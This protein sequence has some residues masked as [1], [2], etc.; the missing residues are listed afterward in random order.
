[1]KIGILTFHR[2]PN[3]G[4]YLQAW[5][6]AEAVRRLGHP[7]EIINYQNPTLYE[8]EQPRL[9]S[10]HPARVRHT[11]RSWLK[12]RP[13][14][15]LVRDLSPGPFATSASNVNWKAYDT[16]VVGSDV[17]WD[18]QTPHFG[19]DPVYFGMAP[20]QQGSR[21]VSY[22][23]SC[24]PAKPSASTPDWVV[25]GLSKFAAIGVR[26]ENTFDLA[27][28][29]A[30]AIPQLVVDPTWLQKDPSS[31]RPLRQAAPYVLVYGDALDS[32]KATSLRAYCRRNGLRLVGAASAW[33]YCDTTVNGF[34]PFQW[35][36]LFSQATAVVTCTLHGLLYSI[37]LRKPFLMVTTEA[38]RQ[39]SRTVL[40][41]TNS[42]DRV[43]TEADPFSEK[44]LE[45]LA[46]PPDQTPK[47]DEA[48]MNT[49][50][51]FLQRAL[52]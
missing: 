2:G 48:W 22:A 8:S 50:R 14:S 32:A 47:P 26:D 7:V 38:S 11:F 29:H 25:E 43:T 52:S 44:H 24:G 41:R 36:E 49:S 39:K 13:F 51:D 21:F 12:S 6:L 5:H 18:Y 46:S 17:V 9:R 35:V 40:D 27:Q 31:G 23:A 42:W 4:G 34:T 1:M 30:S 10:I 3:Y 45:L 15:P 20:A 33:K 37:K 28:R 16:I 19:R